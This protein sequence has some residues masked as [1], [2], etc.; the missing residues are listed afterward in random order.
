MHTILF[1]NSTRSFRSSVFSLALVE[2]V[3]N[4]FVW[5]YYY[6]CFTLTRVS[7]YTRENLV[8]LRQAKNLKYNTVQLN[9]KQMFKINNRKLA[10]IVPRL[11]AEWVMYPICQLR[12]ITVTLESPKSMK[13]HPKFSDL[14]SPEMYSKN[15][16]KLIFIM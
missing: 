15:F 14:L 8:H 2:T 1:W 5:W 7:C 16:L 3:Q 13:V 12:G 11:L 6:V 9:L 4:A 10:F